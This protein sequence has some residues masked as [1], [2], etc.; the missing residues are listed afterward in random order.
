[1]FVELGFWVCVGWVAYIYAGY[2]ACVF[3]LASILKRDV[4][5]A[6]IRPSVTVIISAFNEE[7]EIER[8]VVNKLSQDYPPDRLKVIVVSDGST[9]RTDEILQDLAKRS[10]GRLR[11]LRQEPRQGKTQAL[12]TAIGDTSADVVVFAD[13]N[14]IYAPT[15]IGLLVRSFSDPSVGYVTGNMLYTNSARSAVAEGSGSYMSYENLLRKLETRA[16]SIVGVDGGVD[17][18]RRELYIPMHADQLPDFVLPLSVVEQG[19]RVVYEADAVVYEP[20]LSNPAEEFRMRVRVS[21]RALWALYDKRS[22]LNPLRYPMFAWQ[23]ISHKALRYLA[24]LPLVG[25]LIF[26]ALV[27]VQQGSYG[28][29]LILQVA[30][31]ALAAV[32]HLFRR[33]GAGASWLLTPYY[34]VVLN[35]A[36][37]VA[38]W[39]FLC[40]QKMI[41]WI[42]RQGA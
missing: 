41:L 28:G 37:V 22:L 38:F 18:I 1:M 30:A 23:L 21:L 33:S 19:K 20:A 6:D 24:F 31:Y 27:F 8:T 7:R 4:H 26:N 9:D 39:K 10:G 5:R 12:N 2:A 14:S 11:L 3:L 32:G 25:L 36:C 40:G 17:A 16:G 42:P 34:F 35:V 15:T 13:A 29:L